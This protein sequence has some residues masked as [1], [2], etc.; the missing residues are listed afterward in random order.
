LNSFERMGKHETRPKRKR[1]KK[2]SSMKYS[3]PMFRR[4]STQESLM[5]I[6]RR[7]SP[8]QQ[9]RALV[10]ELKKA[11]KEASQN[12]LQYTRLQH[13]YQAL[14][15]EIKVRQIATKAKAQAEAKARGEDEQ[16][17]QEQEQ[18]R[19]KPRILAP[20]SATQPDV[21]A[22]NGGALLLNRVDRVDSIDSFDSI[23]WDE[24]MKLLGAITDE[25]LQYGSSFNQDGNTNDYIISDC[26]ACQTLGR[27]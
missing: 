2:G 10:K 1:F 23:D 17:E 4:D 11:R 16:E 9:K 3:H 21:S 19:K 14:Q 5:N 6:V 25:T 8:T 27:D 7:T 22:L 18:Q 20:P 26:N 24:T 15:D 13:V 12:T